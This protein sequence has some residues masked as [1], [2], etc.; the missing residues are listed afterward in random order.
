MRQSI[1]DYLK[2]LDGELQATD[3][4]ADAR[5]VIVRLQREN[6]LDF[7]STVGD[8]EGAYLTRVH[9]VQYAAVLDERG[10]DRVTK[11]VCVDNVREFLN[12]LGRGRRPRN[13]AEAIGWFIGHSMASMRRRLQLRK[14]RTK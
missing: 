8:I 11:D 4:A 1:E 7:S 14:H 13:T 5:E 3:V 2:S 6:L 12:W 9:L 10:T